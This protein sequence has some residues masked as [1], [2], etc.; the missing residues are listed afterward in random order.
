M[1]E[2]KQDVSI[3]LTGRSENMMERNEAND[4]NHKY[5]VAETCGSLAIC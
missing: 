3:T 5:A 2:N 1:N 4:K